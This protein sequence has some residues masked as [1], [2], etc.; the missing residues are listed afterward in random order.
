MVLFPRPNGFGKSL[1][2]SML[3]CFFD[4]DK[5]SENK[6]LFDGLKIKETEYYQ[7]LKLDKIQNIKEYVVIFCG[8]KCIVR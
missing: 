7:E 8:K 5:K 6:H 3:D 1:F 2:I 4:I